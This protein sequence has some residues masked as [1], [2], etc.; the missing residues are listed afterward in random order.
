MVECIQVTTT[1]ETREDAET[2]ARL[3][4]AKRLAACVQ[5]SLCCS[6]YHWQGTVEQAD[7]Y[8]IVMKSRPDLYRQLEQCIL[9]NHPYDT[10]EIIGVPLS[11]CSA[12]YLQWMKEELK[13]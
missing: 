10:P 8:K 5:I 2:L 11:L 9:D 12:G 13:S 1:V 4:L 3:V 7:E 6:Y